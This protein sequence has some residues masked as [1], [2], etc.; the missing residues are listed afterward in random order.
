M[1]APIWKD[2]YFTSSAESIT[3]TIKD[4][5]TPIF[6]GKAVKLPGAAN[7]EINVSEIC[8]NFMNNDLPDFSQVTANTQY[9][10]SAA[11]KT[12]YI[13]VDDSVAAAENYTFLWDWSYQDW[14]G[15]SKSMSSPING[16][17][18][19]NMLIFSTTVSQYNEVV[20]RITFGSSGYCGDMALYYQGAAGGWNSYLVEGTVKRTDSITPY[21]YSKSVKNTSIDFEDTK[22]TQD[23]VEGYEI[24]TGWMT[25]TEAENFAENLIK[26]TMVYAHDLRTDKIFP[27]VIDE[28][29]AEFKTYATNSRKPISYTLKIKASQTK[30]RR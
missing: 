21:R 25:E 20:N 4:G 27:V 17:Y 7:L 13:Y 1:K 8:K 11:C 10:N 23:V 16:H 22:Y 29:S 15:S 6:I 18:N 24:R 5:A 19:E 9:S 12:F 14:N 28:S 3:Y 26:S 2:T 30:T